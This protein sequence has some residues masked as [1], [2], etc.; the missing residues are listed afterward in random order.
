VSAVLLTKDS[1]NLPNQVSLVSQAASFVRL[2]RQFA[3]H[4]WPLEGAG[5]LLTNQV[6]A[7]FVSLDRTG[8]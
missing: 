8:S 3:V 5:K 7:K 1:T 4:F 6:E 2:I